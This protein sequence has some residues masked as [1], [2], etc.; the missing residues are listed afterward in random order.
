MVVVII[1]PLMKIKRN[2]ESKN[3]FKYKHVEQM[4]FMSS[5]DGHIDCTIQQNL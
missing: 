4:M 3:I 2:S 1:I 5:L